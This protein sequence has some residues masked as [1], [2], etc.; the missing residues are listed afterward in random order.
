MEADILTAT[1]GHSEVYD[2]DFYYESINSIACK[3]Y[4]RLLIRLYI[5]CKGESIWVGELSKPHQKLRLFAATVT[6]VCLY[7]NLIIFKMLCV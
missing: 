5:P 1:T 2:Y 6:C 7:L 3:V 4:E